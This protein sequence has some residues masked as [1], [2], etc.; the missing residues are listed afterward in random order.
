M[1][2]PFLQSINLNKNEIQ[3]FRIQN[4]ASAPDNPVDGQPYWNTTDKRLYIYDSTNAK[5]LDLY[6]AIQTKGLS[7]PPA[8]PTDG[9]MYWNT[10]TK[11]LYI[12]SA[13]S[14]PAKWIDLNEAMDEAPEHGNEAHTE[15]FATTTELSTGLGGKVDKE[16]GKGLSTEDYTTT[17]KN[18]LAGI[19][20]GAEV[21][22]PT[23]I[24]QGTRTSTTVPI[25][26]STGTGATLE[27]AT[28]SLAGVMSAADKT[29]LD[30][31]TDAATAGKLMLRDAN[32]RAKVANP[33]DSGDIANK[34]YVDALLGA[35]DAMVFKGA[36][37]ATSNPNYP[38]ANAGDAYKI[39]HAGKIGGA[40]GPSVEV[41]DMIIC[42][43]D[44][45]A[46]G[47]HASV[48]GSWVILQANID[49][50]VIGPASATNERIAVFDGTSGKLIKDGGKTLAE[51]EPAIGA[52]GTA[53]NKNF[54]TAT[55]ADAFGTATAGV[56]NDVARADHV[57]ATPDSLVQALAAKTD[58]H[59]ES[60]GNGSLTSFTIT[61]N[62]GTKDV[63]VM[64]RETANPYAQVFCDVEMTTDDTVTVRFA[65][66]PTSNQYR[67]IIIG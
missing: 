45:T 57:H 27:A 31:A 39:S 46:A 30:D 63:V 65:A 26:S 21:N 54:S 5:W 36:I 67:V 64:V 50:A 32:G 62:L 22:V 59:A 8:N 51:L 55:P 25:T 11:H 35:N 41:G 52:K 17:E 58:K 29:K 53:F 43:A 60:I 47:T 16:A 9:Q 37:D 12:Y 14:D 2:I 20:E 61:H 48:G 28:G 24:A 1:A 10:T 7:E 23:N 33:S 38:A 56:S 19:E 4:L 15:D 40:S 42:T 34:A 44:S 3:N 18:K 49:G 66:A 6:T 13:N